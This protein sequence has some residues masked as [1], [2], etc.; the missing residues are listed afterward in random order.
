MTQEELKQ[1]LH[2]DPETGAFTWRVTLGKKGLAGSRAGYCNPESGYVAIKIRGV[3]YF[4]HSLAWLYVHGV[5]PKMVDHR[6]CNPANNAIANL[7]E[8]TYQLNLANARVD[9][10]NKL[11]LKG[12]YRNGKSGYGASITVNY[13]KTYLGTFRSPEEASDAYYEAAKKHFGAFAR[14]A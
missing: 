1:V 3:R 10:R 12:V 14:R 5:F 8:A 13:K 7:R 6:D 2:Y 9:P 4:A 11:G